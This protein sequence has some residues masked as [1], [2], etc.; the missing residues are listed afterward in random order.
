V[1]EAP[2]QLLLFTITRLIAH[3]R[4]S[5]SKVVYLPDDPVARADVVAPQI[6][7]VA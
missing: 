2:H 3:V 4:W 6:L 1:S 5:T 7:D